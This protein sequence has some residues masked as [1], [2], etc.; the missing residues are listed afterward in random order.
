[1]LPAWGRTSQEA[2]LCTA[3]YDHL[4]IDLDRKGH[5]IYNGG[6]DN[7]TGCGVLLEVARLWSQTPA[8]PLADDL[9]CGRNRGR[10]GVAGVRIAREAFGGATEESRW[11]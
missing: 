9:V 5:N 6:V 4:G 11:T 8:V 2:V 10:T 7:A 3:H 1:M